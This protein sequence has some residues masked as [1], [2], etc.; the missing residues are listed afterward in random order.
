MPSGKVCC[1]KVSAALFSMLIQ[2]A[3]VAARGKES[4]M[5]GRGLTSG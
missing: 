5:K 4:R 2:R 1:R 3:G